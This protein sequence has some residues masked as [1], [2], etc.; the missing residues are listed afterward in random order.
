M[1]IY[2]R[3]LQHLPDAWP[4]ANNL[5]FL[6]T[7]HGPRGGSLDK[8]LELALRADR[9]QPHQPAVIDT[10]GW[11]YYH[12]GDYQQALQLYRQIEKLVKEDNP[13]FNYHMAMTLI[14]TDQVEEARALLKDALKE[15]KPFLGRARAEKTLESL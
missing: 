15:K 11:I 4:A 2:E 5:A 7:E 9:I 12:K 14:K 3:A 8:A 1:G 13:L 10:L 6:L